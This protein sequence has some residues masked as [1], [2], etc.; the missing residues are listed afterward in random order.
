MAAVPPIPL[1][2]D[3][4]GIGGD[5]ALAV[6]VALG[7]RIWIELLAD[8]R[9][10]DQHDL[11][12]RAFRFGQGRLDLRRLLVQGVEE[13]LGR[14]LKAGGRGVRAVWVAIELRPIAK[15][16]ELFRRRREPL[17]LEV[18]LADVDVRLLAVGVGIVIS[19]RLWTL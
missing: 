16:L 10:L 5:A 17:P 13:E 12:L 3:A 15:L 6:L 4:V 2:L 19:S 14:D 9:V 7:F 11:E 8:R 18:V 1:V